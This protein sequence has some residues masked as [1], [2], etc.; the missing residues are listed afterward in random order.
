MGNFEPFP[1]VERIDLACSPEFE[2]GG[3]RVC[4]AERVVV[5]NGERRELQPR[6]MQVLVALANAR[7]AVVSRD[8]LAALCWDGRIVGDDALN[9]VILALRRLA[10]EFTPGPFAIETVPRVGHRL[11]ADE[12]PGAT[13]R[14]PEKKSRRN[15]LLGILAAVLIGLAAATLISQRSVALEPASIAVLPFRNLSNDS[16][17]FAEG[18]S[19]EILSRLARE[20]QFRVAGSSSSSQLAKNADLQEIARRLDIDYVVEGTVRRQGDQVR[21]NA[22]LMRAGDGT[23]LWSESYDG[24]LD[25]IFAIQSSIG[26]AIAA[27]LRRKL[28]RAAPLAGPLVTNGN[29]YNLYLTARGLIRTRSRRAGPMAADLLRDALQIDG[30]YAPAWASLGEATLLA[31]ALKDHEG[32]VSSAAEAQRY[33][34]HAVRLAPDLPEAHRALGDLLGFGTPEALAHLRR[35]AELEPN[36]A[37]IMRSLGGAYGAAGRFEEELTAYRRALELDPLWFRAVGSLAIAVAEMGDRSKAEAIARGSLAANGVQRHLLLAKIASS[38]ADYSEAA[39]RWAI[40]IDANSPRWSETARRNRD[41]V[42]FAL[43]LPAGRVVAV[44]RPLDQRNFEWI[45]ADGPPV[46]SVWQRRN[47][48]PLAAVVYRDDNHVAAKLML[49]AGRSRELVAAYDGPGGLIGIRRNVPIRVDQLREAPV[50]ALA[51]RSVGRNAEANRLLDQASGLLD[52]VY[53]RNRVPVWFDADAAALLAVQGRSNEALTRLERAMSRGWRNA[54]ST[55][56]RDL[57][58]EPAFRSLRG[59][60]RFKRLRARLSNH[61]VR[62]REETARV[63]GVGASA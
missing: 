10:G 47:R 16:P 38:S 42:A 7:P 32:F 25:D 5:M 61:F 9:R 36:N 34:R 26:T 8:K 17:Y 40:I 1:A 52:A 37:E 13:A 44:P 30:G 53:S 62:E 46:P 41:Q 55:E 51:L 2:L 33:A 43:G 23:R 24:T 63:L 20:P 12:P 60:P 54:G 22:H 4:P 35:A 58:E 31:G 19:E 15:L 45:P 6:V 27:A 56:L 18:V 14:V 11:V 39:R 28:V 50:A 57:A 29:T 21:V 49:N 48:N 59:N 3:M